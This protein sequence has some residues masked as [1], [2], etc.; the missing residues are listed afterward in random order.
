MSELLTKNQN[1]KYFLRAEKLAEK[2]SL[3]RCELENLRL[4]VSSLSILMFAQD[5]ERARAEKSAHLDYEIKRME[6]QERKLAEDVK[7]VETNMESS[8]EV[9]TSSLEGC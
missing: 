7:Q 9:S 3:K 2:L 8:M 1:L 4:N 5:P 6:E